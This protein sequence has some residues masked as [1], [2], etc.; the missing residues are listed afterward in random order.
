MQAVRVE[1]QLVFNDVPMIIR[2]AVA[3]FGLACVLE[4]QAEAFV[5]DGSLVRVPEDGCSP[6]PGYHL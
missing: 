3:G 5:A 6:F 4:D 2:A 1:G